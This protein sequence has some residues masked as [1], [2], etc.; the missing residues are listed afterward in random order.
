MCT[1]QVLEIL[2]ARQAARPH[3]MTSQREGATLHL[4]TSRDV[5]SRAR[6]G[7]AGGVPGMQEVL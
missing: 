3:A 2:S 1:W 5:T 4:D 6:L 7:A